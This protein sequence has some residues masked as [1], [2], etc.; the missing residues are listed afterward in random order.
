[1]LFDQG[2][3]NAS[4][5]RPAGCITGYLTFDPSFFGVPYIAFMTDTNGS[6][7]NLS[8][9]EYGPTVMSPADFN[10]CMDYIGTKL[11]ISAS[12]AKY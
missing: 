12:C 6:G 10:A 7:W 4:T 2:F 11:N 5:F 9:G 3:V 1:M 8:D